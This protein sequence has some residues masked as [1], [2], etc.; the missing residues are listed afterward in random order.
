MDHAICVVGKWIFDSNFEM[1]L[2]LTT[3]SLDLCRSSE[4]R[5]AKFVSVKRGY[6]LQNR[7]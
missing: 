2:P 7:I 1:A 6:Y 3:E 5:Y 4:D